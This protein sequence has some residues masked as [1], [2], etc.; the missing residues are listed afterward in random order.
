MEIGTTIRYAQKF[1][2]LYP[3]EILGKHTLVNVKKFRI[4]YL[5]YNSLGKHIFV[6]QIFEKKQEFSNSYQATLSKKHYHDICNAK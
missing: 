6:D 5:K 1:N 3:A 2:D 4:R